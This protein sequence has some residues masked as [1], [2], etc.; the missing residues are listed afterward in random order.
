MGRLTIPEK[1]EIARWYLKRYCQLRYTYDSNTPLSVLEGYI[2]SD[3]A[4]THIYTCDTCVHDKD[5]NK[6]CKDC[7]EYNK[8]CFPYGYWG[9]MR[10][11]EMKMIETGQ[12]KY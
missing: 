2:K 3:R 1:S 7:I 4:Y 6:F 10:K 9:K 8:W 12:W 11:I 5:Y